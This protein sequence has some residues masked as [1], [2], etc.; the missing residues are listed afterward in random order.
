MDSISASFEQVILL[1]KSGGYFL[2]NKKIYSLPPISY[3]SILL[4]DREIVYNY[5]FLI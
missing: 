5:L 1:K 2:N 3:Q 4:L